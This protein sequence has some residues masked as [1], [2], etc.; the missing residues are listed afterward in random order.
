ME[1]LI[2]VQL[3]YVSGIK[4]KQSQ[5]ISQSL[6]AKYSGEIGCLVASKFKDLPN[7]MTF[8]TVTLIV[9]EQ[10]EIKCIKVSFNETCLYLD[11]NPPMAY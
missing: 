11:F 8:K 2:L 4:S 5:T 6:Q 10:I 1:V 3:K 9:V 7:S